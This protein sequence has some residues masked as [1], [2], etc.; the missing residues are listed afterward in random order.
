MSNEWMIDVLADLRKFALNQT[1]LDL[2]EHLDDAILVAAT[3][4][5]NQKENQ[6]S[7]VGSY[8]SKAGSISGALEKNGHVG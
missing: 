6:V 7:I 1:M 8:E 3:E 4:I 5:S 2:A